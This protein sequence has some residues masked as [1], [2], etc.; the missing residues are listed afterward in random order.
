MDVALLG[1]TAIIRYTKEIFSYTKNNKY[2]IKTY[3][4]LCTDPPFIGAALAFP[5]Q[6]ALKDF[7]GYDIVHNLTGYPFYPIKRK[8]AKIVTTVHELPFVFYPE[9][10]KKFTYSFKDILW[11]KLVVRPGAYSAMNSDYIICNSINTMKEVIAYGFPKERVFLTE[12]G[13]DYRFL[14][15]KL[16]KKSRKNFRVGFIGTLSP[17]KNV[18]FAINAFK[19]INDKNM[20]FELWG[21]SIYGKDFLTSLIN[22]D[23][24]IKLMGFAP[25]DKLIEI[26]DSF[27]VFVMPSLYE[28]F[29]I[30]IIEAKARG[31]PVIIYKKAHISP[32]VRKYCFEAEDEED[33]ADIIVNL[34]SN[35]YNE[36]TMKKA[37]LHARRFT[38]KSTA[39]ATLVA[40]RKIMS[41]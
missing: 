7:G 12:L 5:I 1:T 27:N 14:H 41:R 17:K 28:G 19:K 6:T 30:P 35:G 4:I 16:S 34:R 10:V 37:L 24:R 3:D 20:E 13:V 25:E 11:D 8:H 26:Y 33:L 18:P 15:T 36:K 31:I 38:W 21:K 23:K 32:E 29:C 9:L 22:N 40:Y 2:G 39:D